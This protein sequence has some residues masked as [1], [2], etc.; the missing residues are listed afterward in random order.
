MADVTTRDELKAL[1]DQLPDDRL[2]SVRRLLD[3]NVNPRPPRPDVERIMRRGQEYRGLVMQRFRET[4]KS[5]TISLASGGGISGVHEGIPYGRHGF[6]YWDDKS[7]VH[8][9]LQNFDVQ[10]IEIMERMSL[11]EDRTELCYTIELASG[12]RTIRHEE[13]F[14]VTGAQSEILP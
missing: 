4:R 10:E 12:G 8:Q 14:P 11:S 13:R 2:E 7:L 1:I 3:H 9:T 5:G 6:D